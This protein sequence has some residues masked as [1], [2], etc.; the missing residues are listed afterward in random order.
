MGLQGRGQ[1]VPLL[2]S[3]PPCSLPIPGW[4]VVSGLAASTYAPSPYTLMALTQ[5]L[6]QP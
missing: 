5:F 2:G 3:D 6:D 1:A 4:A